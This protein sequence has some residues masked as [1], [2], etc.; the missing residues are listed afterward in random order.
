MLKMEKEEVLIEAHQ[1]AVTSVDWSSDG[2][3][4]VTG[5]LDSTV[6]VW[7]SD[8]GAEMYRLVGHPDAV[9]SVDFSPDGRTIASGSWG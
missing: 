2:D 8:T 1:F 5:S 9:Y 3:M 6:R 4:L 7:E